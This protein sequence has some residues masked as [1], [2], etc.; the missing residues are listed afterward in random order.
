MEQKEQ[1]AIEKGMRMLC[2][3][4]ASMLVALVM[5]IVVC[6][7]LAENLQTRSSQDVPLEMFK[8]IFYGLT[9][10]S[11]LL[12]NF[13]KKLLLR[14]KIDQ[15]HQMLVDP[16]PVLHQPLFVTRYFNAVI[17]SL[18]ISGC[19]GLYGFVFFF[20]SADFPTLYTFMAISAAAMLYFRPK[21]EE[22]KKLAA[23]MGSAHGPRE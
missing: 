4:W 14:V 23:V 21:I 12:A 1:E 18:A 16:T 13:L 9:V 11:L 15:P 20:F 10:G 3:I 6:Y 19:I 17:V 2:I 22:L 7:Y 5:Y 8:N